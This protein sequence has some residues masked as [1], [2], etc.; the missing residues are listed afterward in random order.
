MGKGQLCALNSGRKRFENMS[1]EDKEKFKEKN[2]ETSRNW[3][4]KNKKETCKRRREIYLK[5][6]E[7]NKKI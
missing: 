3:Y 6:K 2:R 7:Q 4:L 5:A 1:E